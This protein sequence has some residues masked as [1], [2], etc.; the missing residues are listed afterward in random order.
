MVTHGGSRDRRVFPPHSGTWVD[1]GGQP[2]ASHHPE[3][4]SCTPRGFHVS[5][6]TP[7]GAGGTALPST[8]L[9]ANYDVLAYVSL[10]TVTTAGL[11]RF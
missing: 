6:A 9:P 8:G 7:P 3:W 11:A 1:V 5:S 10:L 2:G 4:G